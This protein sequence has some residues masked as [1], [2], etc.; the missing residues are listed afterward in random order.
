MN[1]KDFPS[2]YFVGQEYVEPQSHES[3][4]IELRLY[5]PA[6]LDSFEFFIQKKK[7]KGEQRG[8]VLFVSFDIILPRNL[9]TDL[10][11]GK[12]NAQTYVLG[13]ISRYLPR[14]N[15]EM[16]EQRYS[17]GHY[18]IQTFSVLDVFKI[19]VSNLNPDLA[20]E[21]I[22][23]P[24]P[25]SFKKFPPTQRIKGKEI[26]TYLMDFIDA[27]NDYLRGDY[28][29]CIRRI[30]TS[31]E[32]AFKFYKLD[33]KTLIGWRRYLS[34]L[35]FFRE[36]S[37]NIIAR[38]IST[39][40]DL[41]RQVVSENLLFLYK[42]RNRI[43]HDKFRIRFENSLVCRKGISTLNYLYQF[44]GQGGNVAEYI[45]FMEGQLKMLDGELRGVTM[46]ALRLRQEGAKQEPKREDIIDSVKKMNE[47]MFGSLR[48]SGEEQ[49]VVLKNKIPPNFYKN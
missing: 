46:E 44:L 8:G 37:F 7:I 9:L 48:I 24:W 15:Q 1:N 40:D 35:P 36:A 30:I 45:S 21:V 19:T 32:N 41:G 18:L 3:V 2:S 34:F 28:N 10:A 5:S 16:L 39:H 47:W 23:V 17:S 26:E 20:D 31:A 42:L 12:G 43:V 14:I 13:Y 22:T 49:R 27:G 33:K 29:N 38:S 11:Y 25:P 6:V 4:R